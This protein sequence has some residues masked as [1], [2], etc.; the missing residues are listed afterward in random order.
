ML[1]AVFFQLQLPP[2]NVPRRALLYSRTAPRPPLPLRK[3]EVR[4]QADVEFEDY[5]KTNAP[6]EGA[7]PCWPC[8][9]C[10][11]ARFY[12][13]KFALIRHVTD[14]H[15]DVSSDTGRRIWLAQSDICCLVWCRKR[16]QSWEAILQ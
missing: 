2:P 6:E 10:M 5:V 13:G 9:F 1:T 7:M 16:T 11:I 8:Q 14:N 12:P 3:G 4:R 15:Q